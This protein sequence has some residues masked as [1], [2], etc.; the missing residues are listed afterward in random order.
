MDMRKLEL[1]RLISGEHGINYHRNVN[2]NGWTF[3]Y[4]ESFI[5]FELCEVKGFMIA[6]IDYIFVTDT[7]ALIKLFAQAMDFWKGNEVKY[8]YYREHLR[9]ANAA[10]NYIS[11]NLGLKIITSDNFNGW[12]YNWVSTNCFPE[13]EILEA[14]TDN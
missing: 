12:K 9:K 14:I 10:E 13:S 4:G 6:K 2:L 8:I 11:K 5:T 3:Y 1:Q 7:T